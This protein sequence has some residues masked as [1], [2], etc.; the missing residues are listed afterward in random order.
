M[1]Y[2]KSF[3][4]SQIINENSEEMPYLYALGYN[5]VK[6]MFES[7]LEKKKSNV[8]LVRDIIYSGILDINADEYEEGNLT[9]LHVA[10]KSDN[11]EAVKLLLECG[12]DMHKPEYRGTTTPLD[13]ALIFQNSKMI[14]L[15]LNKIDNINIQDDDGRSKLHDATLGNRY[16]SARLLLEYG[17]NPNIRDF[18]DGSTPMFIAIEKGHEDILIL[19]LQNG[20]EPNAVNDDGISAGECAISNGREEFIDILIKFGY[21]N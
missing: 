6:E 11:Y 12:A 17:A 1:K 10:T 8:E 20:A 18:I 5:K 2:L 7:E 15:F 3:E 9:P 4:N 19:L 13:F 21:D 16:T 14:R